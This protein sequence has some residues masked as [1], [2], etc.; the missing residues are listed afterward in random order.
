MLE[1][2]LPWLE[3]VERYYPEFERTYGERYEQRYGRWRPIIGEV[4]RKFLRCGDLHYGFARVRCGDCGH[5]R[6]WRK[7]PGAT[8]K[9][10]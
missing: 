6:R 9:T 1:L 2:H 5:E 10:T 4:A 8:G 3:L 7:S